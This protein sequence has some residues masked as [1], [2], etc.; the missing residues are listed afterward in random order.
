MN[1]W[2]EPNGLKNGCEAE[3][4]TLLNETTS[5]IVHECM[6]GAERF[7]KWLRCGGEDTT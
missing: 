6:D 5:G 1:V 2:M 7:K 3:Q 4:R